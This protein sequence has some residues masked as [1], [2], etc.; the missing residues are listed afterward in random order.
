M[1]DCWSTFMLRC[2]APVLRIDN[3]QNF[4]IMKILILLESFISLFYRIRGAFDLS[5]SET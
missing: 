4:K 2:I 3:Q 1:D 5:E